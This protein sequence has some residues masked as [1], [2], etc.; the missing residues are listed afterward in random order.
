[1]HG[2]LYQGR[3]YTDDDEFRK[4]IGTR[5]DM[6]NCR[7]F[8][9][10]SSFIYA[11]D[12]IWKNCVFV[13]T[14]DQTGEMKLRLVPWDTDQSFGNIWSPNANLKIALDISRAEKDF[15]VTGPYLLGKLW[16]LD[17]GGFRGSAANRWFEL[18]KGALS[19]KSLFTLIDGSFNAITESGARERDAARW[20]NSAICADNTFI[21]EFVSRRL[22]HLDDYYADV[23]AEDG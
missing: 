23:F 16:E 22:Q 9:L 4:Q 19:E 12:N 14:E 11:T 13:Q 10:F 3:Y 18:R 8:Y 5:L 6:L 2:G 1:M 17:A 7:D 15:A 20:P 21:N